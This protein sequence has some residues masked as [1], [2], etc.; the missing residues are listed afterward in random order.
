[1][2]PHH[3][4]F[5]CICKV[6]SVKHCRLLPIRGF[7]YQ[8]NNVIPG[9]YGSPDPLTPHFMSAG[10]EG[11]PARHELPPEEEAAIQELLRRC[12]S[13]GVC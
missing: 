5:E 11:Q 12:D 3:P 1:M 4:E 2:E 13:L 8:R 6:P 9:G 7:H 10:G